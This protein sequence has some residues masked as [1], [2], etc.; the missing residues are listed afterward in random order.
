MGERSCE[1][2]KDDVDC[3]VISLVGNDWLE[4]IKKQMPIGMCLNQ[5]M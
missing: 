1:H 4:Q 5:V 3:E 2:C